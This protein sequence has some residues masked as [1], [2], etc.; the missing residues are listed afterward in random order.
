VALVTASCSASLS[1][2]RRFPV[3]SSL[4]IF[5]PRPVCFLVAGRSSFVL[6][7][8]D[9]FEVFLVASDTFLTLWVSLSAEV[10]MTLSTLECLV[11]GLC[12]LELEGSCF[13]EGIED[14]DLECDCLT[15]VPACFYKNDFSMSMILC[16]SP[17]QV[18]HY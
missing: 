17:I 7:F 13:D 2:S 8:G 5:C 10:D 3:K 1:E 11:L 4:L 9:D 12:L 14:P 16:N 15:L 18:Y 6:A